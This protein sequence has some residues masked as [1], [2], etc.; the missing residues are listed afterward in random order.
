MHLMELISKLCGVPVV[1]PESHSTAVVRGAAILAR[2]A[3]EVTA[4]RQRTADGKFIIEEERMT[5][6]RLWDIMVSNSM[7]ASLGVE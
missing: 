3:S 2:H 4:E 6:G 5:S 7:R 1:I